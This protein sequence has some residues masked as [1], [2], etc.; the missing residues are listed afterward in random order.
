VRLGVEAYNRRDLEAAVVGWDPGF[1]Y[2]PG[3][4]WVEEGLVEPCYRGLE[5]FR[6]SVEVA[7][8][9]AGGRLC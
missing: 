3:R 1:E 9:I 2:H 7:D 6:R 4:E 8:G 5:G